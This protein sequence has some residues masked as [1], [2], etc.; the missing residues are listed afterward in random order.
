MF[1]HHHALDL[2]VITYLTAD[3]LA[4]GEAGADIRHIGH[5]LTVD[6]AGFFL[7]IVDTHQADNRVGVG[8]VDML[9]RHKSVQQRLDALARAALLKPG[10]FQISDHFFVGHCVTLVERFDLVHFEQGELRFLD[11]QHVRPGR[12]DRQHL[13]LPPHMI[14]HHDFG[15]GIP[16]VNIHH[17]PVTAQDIA[18][19][20]QPFQIRQSGCVSVIPEILWHGDSPLSDFVCFRLLTI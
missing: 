6:L 8:V 11:G 20:Y 17:G 5:A 14:G 12:L 7:R 9:A 13:D 18:A 10:S 19:I 4:E 15:A 16:A 1:A 2:R 3:P